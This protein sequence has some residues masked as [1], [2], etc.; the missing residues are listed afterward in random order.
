MKRGEKNIKKKYS[1]QSGFTLIELMVVMFIMALGIS[2]TLASFRETKPLDEV[3]AAARQIASL[4]REAQNNSLAGKQQIDGTGALK[5]ICLNGLSW[6]GNAGD[7]TTFNLF[8][9]VS[10]SPNPCVSANGTISRTETIKKVNIGGA[11]VN[12]YLNFLVPN[13]AVVASGFSPSGNVSAKIQVISSVNNSVS[14]LVCV[15]NT[16]RVEEV[17]G[18]ANCP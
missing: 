8:S 7:S 4:I 1:A 2:L 6:Q 12:D 15:Y 9:Y 5:N 18:S 11:A 13:G 10:A 16:G 17:V 14:A 3:E